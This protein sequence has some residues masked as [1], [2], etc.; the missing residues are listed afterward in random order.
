MVQP[1]S[2]LQVGGFLSL[3]GASIPNSGYGLCGVLYLLCLS[4]PNPGCRWDMQ[5]ETRHFEPLFDHCALL[6]V[7]RNLK[8]EGWVPRHEAS[9]YVPWTRHWPDLELTVAGC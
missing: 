2:G 1:K 5:H 6:C 9:A 3:S 8:N 7:T 4:T